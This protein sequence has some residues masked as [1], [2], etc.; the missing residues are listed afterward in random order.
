TN[1]ANLTVTPVTDALHNDVWA[2]FGQLNVPIFSDNNAIIGFRRLELEAS[3][4]H[5]Q[6]ANFGG[7]S[8]PKVAFNWSPIDDFTIKG[9]W[10]S[11]FRAP[12]FAEI[13]A[14]AKGAINPL[15]L[16]VSVTRA[17]SSPLNA[18]ATAGAALP[19]PT[20]GA[21]K[22]QLDAFNFNNAMA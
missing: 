12:Q 11:N 15:N 13:S 14:I 5:D 10:G 18:C 19:A 21:G 3:W 20:S 17:R 1:G 22:E 6:Y 2:V 9:A 4:R 16:P 7:T 8:N